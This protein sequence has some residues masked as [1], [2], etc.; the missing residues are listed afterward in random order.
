MISIYSFSQF[1]LPQRI[2]SGI[3]KPNACQ[4][5]VLGAHLDGRKFVVCFTLSILGVCD[6]FNGSPLRVYLTG[7]VLLLLKNQT[8]FQTNC[9]KFQFLLNYLYSE[10]S[11]IDGIV[12]DA[13][14]HYSCV[15]DFGSI[16]VPLQSLSPQR[17]FCEIC[18]A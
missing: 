8:K 6:T 9:R 2:F 11:S 13:A 16:F 10:N 3:N 1:L 7:L 5:H 18:S 17:L 15:A 12:I 14:S 4:I